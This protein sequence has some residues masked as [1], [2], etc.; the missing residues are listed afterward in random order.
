MWIVTKQTLGASFAL[1]LASC[2]AVS[3]K[4][5]ATFAD[6][7]AGKTL[8]G[9]STGWA[10]VEAEADLENGSGPLANPLLGGSDVGSSTT[11]LDP[12]FGAGLKLL[13]F[14][15]NN[16]SIGGLFEHR[17]FDPEPTR[18]L[19]A[20]LDIDDFGTNHFILDLRY[21]FN[22]LD[23]DRRFRPFAAV[24]FGFVPAVNADGVVRYDEITA[25]GLPATTED[26]EL[27]GDEFFTLGFVVGGSVL[28]Q[29]GLTFDFGA[30]YEVALDPTEDQITLQPYPGAP[31]VGDPTTYDGELRERGLY[32]TVGLSYTF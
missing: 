1:T 21:W 2:M 25:L 10:F 19:D 29:R 27:R 23:R 14:I 9:V 20:E 3:D 28:I 26:I 17:I 4:D 5:V 12:V 8:V 22:A 7:L 32:L 24:Q 31:V 15:N 11:D 16:W 13:H 30:F 18:P 6:G